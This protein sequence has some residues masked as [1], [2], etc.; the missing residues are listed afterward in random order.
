MLAADARVVAE[1]PDRRTRLYAVGGAQFYGTLL[2]GDGCGMPRRGSIDSLAVSAG[3]TGPQLAK[4]GLF[5]L[6]VADTADV[7]HRIST[8]G[9]GAAGR[10]VVGRR[11]CAWGVPGLLFVQP[12]AYGTAPGD[13]HGHHGRIC[14]AGVGHDAKIF[15]AVNRPYGVV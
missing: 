10:A 1:V 11:R 3:P 2:C 12:G 8:Q 6:L 15:R 14:L 9:V 4:S 5:L 13:G 7:G